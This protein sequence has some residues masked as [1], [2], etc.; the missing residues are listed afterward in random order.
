MI[1]VEIGKVKCEGKTAENFC[2]CFENF[3]KCGSAVHLL[4]KLLQKF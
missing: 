2:I 1:K 3:L 4:K